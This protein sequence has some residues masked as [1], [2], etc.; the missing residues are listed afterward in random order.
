VFFNKVSL[1]VGGGAGYGTSDQTLLDQSTTSIPGV[2]ARNETLDIS[3][4]V[5]KTKREMR[6]GVAH[7]KF[8]LA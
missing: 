7:F 6:R 4:M 5:G 2:P 8:N 3:D 1:A